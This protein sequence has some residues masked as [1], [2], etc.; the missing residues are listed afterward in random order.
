MIRQMLGYVRQLWFREL[1]ASKG[2]FYAV[3]NGRQVGVVE[4]WAECEQLVKGFAR[5]RFKKFSTRAEADRFVAG[6]D[7]PVAG[8]D[9]P[10]AS[11]SSKVPQNV[12]S[13]PRKKATKR[14]L[15]VTPAAGSVEFGQNS[16]QENTAELNA[17]ILTAPIIKPQALGSGEV[18]GPV[19][20]TDGACSGNGTGNARAGI[21][22]YWGDGDTRN[23]SEPL[24]G[25]PT[26]NRAEIHAAVAAVRQAKAQGF[27]CVEIRTDSD[28]LIK[29]VTKWLPSWQRNS[30]KSATGKPVIN[31]EDFEVLLRATEGIDVTWRHVR[32]HV[33]IHGNEMADSL[34]V[35]GINKYNSR[36]ESK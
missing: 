8:E 30:W 20:Y 11:A 1:M 25:R 35:A 16:H 27:T 36:D 34:A 31:K 24:E 17:K 23:I 32:G 12:S 19:I 4:T 15:S 22:V 6:E 29:S 2:S 10:A 14:K 13:E 26:N 28:F 33:G 18:K 7:A 9:A 21:G 3:R 5:A